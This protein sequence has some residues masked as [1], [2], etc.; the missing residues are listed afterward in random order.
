MAQLIE[1]LHLHPIH[2]IPRVVSIVI[3]IVLGLVIIVGVFGLMTRFS[4]ASDTAPRDVVISEVTKNSVK[5]A[6]TTDQE[7]QGV[8]EYGTS[9]TAL[10]FFAPETVRAKQHSLDLTLLSPGT[11]YYFQ[12]RISDNKFDNGGVPWTFTTKTNNQPSGGLPTV[13]PTTRAPTSKPTPIQSL[14]IPDKGNTAPAKTC[15]YTN[16]E[17]IKSKIGYGCTQQQYWQCKD[18]ITP[19]ASPS[20]TPAAPTPTTVVVP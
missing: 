12:I 11:S 3:G 17:T 8:I 15:T 14:V 6:W 19:T 16:C 20:A 4:K 13:A 1:T 2:R 18:K 10:N 5:V 9:A 7:T